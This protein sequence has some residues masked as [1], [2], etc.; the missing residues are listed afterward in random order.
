[1]KKFEEAELTVEKFEDEVIATS[2]WCNRICMVYCESYWC[3]ELEAKG[4][5][6]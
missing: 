1:M 3:E 5:R 4:E 2:A 6:R